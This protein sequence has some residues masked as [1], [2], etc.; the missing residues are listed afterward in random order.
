MENMDYLNLLNP[1]QRLAVTAG[2]GQTLV[3][4]GPGSGKTRVLTQRIAYLIQVMGVRPQNILAVTFTNKA[5]REM[6][7][8]LETLLGGQAQGVWLGTFHANCAKILRRE[9]QY[10]PFDNNFVIMDSDD[11]LAIVKRV[12]KELNIDE[13]S[14]RPNGVHAAIS[15]AKNNLITAE[16][17][18]TDSYRDEVIKRVYE[19]YQQLLHLSNAVD[20]DDL[21]LETVRLM[22]D[23]PAV[24]ERYGRRFEH[25]LVD[26]FQDT[27]LVQ[28]ELLK[29]LASVHQNLFVVGDEDQ[30]IYRWRGA[31][32]RNVLNFE[33]YY[34]NCQV[35]LLEQ[36][37]RS[38][39]TVLDAARAV[40]D[41]N[42]YR[43]PKHLFSDRGRGDRVV[44]YDAA[45]DRSE[46][47][48]VVDTIRQWTNTGRVSGGD[49]AV[50]YRTNA[51]SRV[52]EEAFLR[53][54]M[55]YR[56][57]GATRFYGRREVKDI[58]AYLRLV[59]NP[60]DEISMARVINVPTRGIGDKTVLTLQASARQANTTAGKVLL[61]LG[62]KGADSAFIGLFSGRSGAA[63]T[64]FGSM[65]A[66]WRAVVQDGISLPAL[67][68]RVLADTA[69]QEYIDDG[70]EEGEERWENVQ[71]LRRLAY[72]FSE[73]GLGAFLENL[74]LVSDQDT[75]PEEAAN[76]PT[77]LTLHAAKGLEFGTVFI[78]GLDDGL[79]P[80][81]RAKDDEEELAEERRLFYV[82]ITRAR[83]RVYLVRAGQRSTYGAPEEQIPSEFLD[84]IPEE[85]LQRQGQQRRS[86]GSD[87]GSR[88]KTWNVGSARGSSSGSSAS[89]T[90][91]RSTP[92][93]QSA[94]PIIEQR[95]H[96][97]DHVQHGTWG[98]G[99]VMDSRVQDGDETV[100]VYFDSVGF[101]RVVASLAKLEIVPK[102]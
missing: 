31:D 82:G 57:V 27:N 65:L 74:A 23:Q 101:K 4:A 44:L 100:D 80:H 81:S 89:S 7:E 49:F 2:L 83:D 42:K 33:E 47:A 51:Q 39:Q 40:I 73:Q 24:R 75:L 29:L 70:S 13:K 66:G 97:A 52:L 58:I 22:A 90:V 92:P 26:E 72:E 34:K 6:G 76:A 1:Q 85:L 69:Y 62:L 32:Y 71:E 16:D 60:D 77:L 46:A 54:G 86:Y 12:L 96:P 5:A 93:A 18:P 88:P 79:L 3:L 68:D 41:R 91:W 25:V 59:F 35:V 8:R 37:Y 99:I 14:F 43:T 9:A 15:T 45:D 11:Q 98:H 10:L 50:L 63:L 84:D 48:F 87:Y 102:P 95:Y 61:D 53:A 19:R 55:P 28:Y 64:D 36:N 17:F 67:Y 21:L 20:F 94:A 56:L 38:T 78:I 30:S